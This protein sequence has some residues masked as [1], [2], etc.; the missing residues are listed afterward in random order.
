MALLFFGRPPVVPTQSGTPGALASRLRGNG[1][2]GPGSR[3]HL[4]P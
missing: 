4:P 1:S 2:H 3:Y